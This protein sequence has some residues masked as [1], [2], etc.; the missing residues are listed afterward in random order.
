MRLMAR[1]AALIGL[2]LALS[3]CSGATPGLGINGGSVEGSSQASGLTPPPGGDAELQVV[4]DL[5]TPVSSRGGTE[6]LIIAGDVIQMEIFGVEKLNRTVQVNT[7]GA[8]TLPLIG[9]VQAAG[10]TVPAF[11]AELASLY[12]RSYLQ[13]PSVTIQIKESAVRRVI[14]DGEV[15]RSGVFPVNSRSTLVEALAQAGG[16]SQV[17]DPTKVYV[18]RTVD[19]VR[20]VANFNVSD[21]RGGRRSNPAIYGGDVIVVFSSDARVAWQNLKEALGVARSV[22]GAALVQ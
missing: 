4:A 17:A 16:F 14:V 15:L 18:F 10:K 8:V 5:P 11:E 2:G 12:G 7:N 3:A 21:I 1:L 22:T 13:N 19:N 6:D 9:R 20:M